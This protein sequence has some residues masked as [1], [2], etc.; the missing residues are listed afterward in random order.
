[1]IRSISGT[2]ATGTSGFG[3][4]SVTGR[5][6]VPSPAASNITSGNRTISLMGG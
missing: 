2:P 3:I 5:N 4:V 1:M 6:R